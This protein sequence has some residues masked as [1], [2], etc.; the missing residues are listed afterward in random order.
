MLLTKGH[1]LQLQGEMGPQTLSSMVDAMNTR[2][3][4]VK[5]LFRVCGRGGTPGLLQC[6]W[7]SRRQPVLLVLQVP[8][9]RHFLQS[10]LAVY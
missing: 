2:K 1:Q 3:L 10:L 4:T 9:T 7:Y 5:K 6:T 8:G